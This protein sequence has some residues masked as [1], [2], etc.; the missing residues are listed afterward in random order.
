MSR[1]GTG[2][3]TFSIPDGFY[4]GKTA[5]ANDSDLLAENIK[6]GVNLFGVA[7]GLSGGDCT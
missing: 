6:S 7:G 2:D 5:T 1:A 4:E 3:K